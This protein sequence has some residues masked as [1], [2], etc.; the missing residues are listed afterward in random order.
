MIVE[1][2]RARRNRRAQRTEG[3]GS[4]GT[5]VRISFSG[6]SV[7]VL[8]G[9]LA[10][11]P[12]CKDDS[13]AVVS[14][15]TRSGS[16]PGVARFRVYVG[17]GSALDTLDYYPKQVSKPLVLDD[18]HPVTFSVEFSTARGGQATFEVE[19]L[20]G[21][22]ATLGYGKTDTTIAKGNVFKV[23]VLIELG[24]LRPERGMDAGAGGDSGT[25]PLSCDPYAPASACGAGR[26]CGLLCS[27][28]EPAIG[29]CYAAGA[30]TP[31]QVC[32]SNNECAP[33]S[34]CF[35]FSATEVGCSVRTCLRF[36]NNDDTACSEPAAY[37]NVPI[38]CGTTPPFVACSRPC[39]P[40]G[41]G[42]VVCATGLACFVYEHETTDCACPGLGAAG[43]ACTRNQGCSGEI[44]CAG[45]AAGL[46]CVFPVGGPGAC[47][48]I[49]SL[50]TGNCPSGTTCHAFEGSTRLLYG[51]CQ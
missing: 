5:D 25:S 15:L 34:Q 12:A 32:T 49:C 45:C 50:A 47:R 44:G 2:E 22:G 29:M 39:D 35:T 20:D 26:T 17:N 9:L 40:T 14:V 43:S 41:S 16:V 13:Y 8:L 33:G 24:A 27:G 3:K 4:S 46:S 6:S 30:G 51:F 28:G 31:G 18:V 37:C 1:Q 42:S 19:A 48:P 36:C 23:T 11:V 38:E 21:G 10:V 7:A